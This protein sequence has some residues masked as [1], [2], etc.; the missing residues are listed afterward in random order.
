MRDPAGP[1]GI[2]Q[3]GGDML[4]ADD[5]LKTLRT[6]FAGDDLIRHGV[7]L[8]KRPEWSRRESGH[9]NVE[10]SSLHSCLGI[11]GQ[12]TTTTDLKRGRKPG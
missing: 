9:L 12:F 7:R 6:I 2:H 3:R 10:S 5:I 4:L 11:R 8:E 1:D